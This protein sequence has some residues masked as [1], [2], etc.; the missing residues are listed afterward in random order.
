MAEKLK[1]VLLEEPSRNSDDPS[2]TEDQILEIDEKR[3]RDEL[4]LER[5][6]G[7]WAGC[8]SSFFGFIKK[9]GKLD[10]NE[11]A[12]PEIDFAEIK[13]SLVFVGSGGQ[14]AVYRGKYKG[15]TVAVKMVKDVR[16]TETHHLNSL[17][18]ANIVHFR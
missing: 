4:S 11:E 15:E 16:E 14:G 1:K 9:P 17:R 6:D 5:V 18:H 3:Q 2:I 13:D 12:V 7:A 8:F 10:K